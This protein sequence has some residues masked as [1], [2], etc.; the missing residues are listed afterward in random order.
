MR[1]TQW[2]SRAICV[3]APCHCDRVIEI[4]CCGGVKTS[5]AIDWSCCSPRRLQRDLY[6]S[7]RS[8]C[9]HPLLFL[10]PF[11]F[12]ISIAIFFC[13]CFAIVCDACGCCCGD[14]PSTRCGGAHPSL[15]RLRRLCVRD[16]TW[17]RSTLLW[18]DRPARSVCA[19]PPCSC[20]RCCAV[21]CRGSACVHS[22]HKREMVRPRTETGARD[23]T[24][25]WRATALCDCAVP[26]SLLSLCSAV[27][28]SD[29]ASLCRDAHTV[30]TRSHRECT[31]DGAH[32]GRTEAARRLANAKSA[33]PVPSTQGI[34]EKKGWREER[35]LRITILVFVIIKLS[36]VAC[37]PGISSESFKP[38]VSLMLAKS[39]PPSTFIVQKP[40]KSLY[41]VGST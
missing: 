20:A 11:L 33:D 17:M 37:H 40:C 7:L 27:R 41:Q 3:P 29:A 35:K 1:K 9:L 6:R 12:V 26:F 38:A 2:S 13:P 31:A 10:C 28:G 32:E 18:P 39:P 30:K 14:D 25:L 23:A 21:L 5:V 24:A 34:R 19:C 22:A 15:R 36:G 16:W 4:G 8:L